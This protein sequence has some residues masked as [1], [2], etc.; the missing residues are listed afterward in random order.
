MTIV[1]IRN[2]FVI[3]IIFYCYLRFAVGSEIFHLFAFMSD[4]CKF[5]E[6]PVG[7]LNCQRHII[8]HFAAGITEHHSL[9]ACSLFFRFFTN[10][11]L[12]DIA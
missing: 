6:K 5:L 8:I 9:V 2:R 1:S 10:N 3:I 7:K 12:I 11:S 4:C